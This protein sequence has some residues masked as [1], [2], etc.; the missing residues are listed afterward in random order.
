MEPPGGVHKVLTDLPTALCVPC[1]LGGESG[2]ERYAALYKRS[3]F[4]RIVNPSPTN[5]VDG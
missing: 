2:S 3:L 1:V 4:G 5:R